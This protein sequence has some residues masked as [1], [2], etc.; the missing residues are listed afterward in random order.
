MKWG[1][2]VFTQ[3]GDETSPQMGSGKFGN[4]IYQRTANMINVR[5]IENKYQL[6]DSPNDI[7][8]AESRCYLEGDHSYEDDKVGY[9]FCFGGKG[10]TE[11]RCYGH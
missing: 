7:Q 5:Y 3:L 8:I 9:T 2:Y 4:E 6:V 1:G 10:G 11:E